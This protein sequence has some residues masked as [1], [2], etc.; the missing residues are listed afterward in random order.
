MTKI[1]HI[2][3]VCSNCKGE[4]TQIEYS[5]RWYSSRYANL[6]LSYDGYG[7]VIC[8][9]CQGTGVEDLF[10]EDVLEYTEV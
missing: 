9:K 1:V 7:E 3:K 6:S 2:Q 5:M 10:I 8:D 4:G